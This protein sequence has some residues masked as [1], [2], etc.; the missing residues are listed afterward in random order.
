MDAYSTCRRGCAL[1]AS[2]GAA[3]L[4]CQSYLFLEWLAGRNLIEALCGGLLLATR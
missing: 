2:L 3:H 1:C 4:L